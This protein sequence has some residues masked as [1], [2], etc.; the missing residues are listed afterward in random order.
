MSQ[1]ARKQEASYRQVYGTNRRIVYHEPVR[2]SRP[3]KVNKSVHSKALNS[4]ALHSGYWGGGVR[5]LSYAAPAHS[6][7]KKQKLKHITKY[8]F[9]EVAQQKNALLRITAYTA[10][11]LV[12]FLFVLSIA[13][14]DSRRF[15]LSMYNSQLN[16]LRTDNI[17]LQGTVTSSHSLLEVERYA[18]EVLGMIRPDDSQIIYVDELRVS[19]M[20]LFYVDT[21]SITPIEALRDMLGSVIRLFRVE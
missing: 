14:V 6:I 9:A 10:V 16:R 19:Y 7:K 5:K 13:Y 17:V 8:E 1:P 3:Q 15:D 20:E 4:K 12:A 2:V 11:L 21:I 18:M